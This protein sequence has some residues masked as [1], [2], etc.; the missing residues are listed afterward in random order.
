MAIGGYFVN[1]YWWLFHCKPLVLT[2]LVVING[3]FI[4]GYYV[5]NYCWL[6]Y[7]ILQLLV[8]ILS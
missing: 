3:Y 7:V 4:N 1:G 8:I 2:L 5:I 6:L